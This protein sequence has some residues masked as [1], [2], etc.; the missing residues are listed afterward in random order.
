MKTAPN[1]QCLIWTLMETRGSLVTPD[2]ARQ[3]ALFLFMT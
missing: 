2:D 3:L 1:N